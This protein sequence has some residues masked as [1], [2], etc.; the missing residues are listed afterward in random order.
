MAEYST[1]KEPAIFN[2]ALATLMRLD[3]ILIKIRDISTGI[4]M[5]W[6]EGREVDKASLLAGKIAL[7]RQFYLNASPLLKPDIKVVLKKKM[8]FFVMPQNYRLDNSLSSKRYQ[9]EVYDLRLDIIIDNF[10]EEVEQR[11]QDEGYFMP[12][13]NDPRFAFKRD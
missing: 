5:G 9:V 13:K 11:L 1:S 3:N 12:P 10:V 2:M 4:S 7:A 6:M 8:R